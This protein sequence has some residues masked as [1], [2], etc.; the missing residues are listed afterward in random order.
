MKRNVS[1]KNSR[2]LVGILV[3]LGAVLAGIWRFSPWFRTWAMGKAEQARGAAIHYDLLDEVEA[4]NIRQ[5]MTADPAHSRV[6]MW[7]SDYAVKEPVLEY[8]ME[9]KENGETVPVQAEKFTDGG[10]NTWIYRARI[11]G[12]EPGQTYGYRIRDGKKATAWM[13]LKAFAGNTFKALVFP[14]SQSADY[15]AWKATAQPA[16]QRNQDAQFFVNMGDQ[17]D[18]GQDASQWNAWFDVVEPMAEKIPMATTVGN[19]ETYDLNWKVRRPEAYMKL[20]NLPQ[21]GYAQYPN[22]FYSFTVGD[23]H[24]V[25]LDTVFSEMKDLE[26]NLEQDEIQWFRKDMEQNRQ[27]W[28][29]VVMHKDPLRYAFNPATGRTGRDEGIEQEGKVWM[30]LFD[31][32]GIDLVLS[33]HLHTYR[34]RG[35]IRDFRHNPD[36]PLYILTGVAGDVRYPGL[37][38]QHPLDEYVAPQPET[39]NYLVMTKTDDELQLQ[40][41][42]P[43][44]TLLDTAT[45]EKKAQ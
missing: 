14:D 34:N 39:D 18:N 19:H 9:G 38:K 29:I 11:S 33:A 27:K 12:L 13:S 23:V 15:S 42:L 40:A 20:F 37:W 36:G 24:F 43:D 26:P 17:V 4:R 3:L 28:N 8:R 41:F 22:R 6:I 21:N 7:Q 25:V 16:W 10:K 45:M 31:E 5:V 44:G 32:Y 30:P 35:H 1:I 2:I